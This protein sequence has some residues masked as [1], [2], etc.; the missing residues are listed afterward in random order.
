[1]I[2]HPKCEECVYNRSC[3]YEKCYR[4]VAWFK[5]EWQ[6]IRRAA[7]LMKEQEGDKKRE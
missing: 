7:E 1:M 3:E 5:Q 6:T 4:W 2:N